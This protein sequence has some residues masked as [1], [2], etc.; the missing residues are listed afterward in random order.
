MMMMI[1]EATA[2]VYKTMVMI[3]DDYDDDN[4]H[5]KVGRRG[6]GQCSLNL[7]RQKPDTSNYQ[8]DDDYNNDVNSDDGDD[9][10]N[11]DYEADQP[12]GPEME[13]KYDHHCS[14]PV[15]K[16]GKNLKRCNCKKQKPKTLQEFANDL[17]CSSLLK[18]EC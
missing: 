13:G 18:D 16:R 6:R 8:H 14:V 17:Q 1:R 5:R 12:D 15:T 7:V 4:D 2:A 10:D 3:Y 9:D 11:D